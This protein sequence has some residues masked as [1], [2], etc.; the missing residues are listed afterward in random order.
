MLKRAKTGGIRH[1]VGIGLGKFPACL[2]Y[3]F[4][5]DFPCPAATRVVPFVFGDGLAVHIDRVVGILQRPR[6]TVVVKGGPGTAIQ[7]VAPS[8]FD[9]CLEGI[10]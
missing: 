5:T 6:Q 4:P 7:N 1:N 8:A 9:N 10:S 3:L 2:V